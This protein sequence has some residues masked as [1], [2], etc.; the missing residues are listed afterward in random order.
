MDKAERD[1]VLYLEDMQT[2][3]ERLMRYTDALDFENF[4]RNYLVLD[5]V[6][7]N[8]SKLGEAAKK[9][10]EEIKEKYPEMPWK[11]MYGL[12]NLVAHEY[13]GLNTSKLWEII[14]ENIPANKQE[15]DRILAIE[16]Q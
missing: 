7:M 11:Q 5:A 10:P 9:V 4:E 14:I 15:I 2:A 12:R 1:Y 3:L 6:M 8:F 16:T 13:F